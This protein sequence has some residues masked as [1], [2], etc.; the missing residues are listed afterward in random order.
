MIAVLTLCVILIAYIARLGSARPPRDHLGDGLRG[1]G[2]FAAGASGLG[3]L[4][5]P[6]TST[7]AERVTELALVFLLFS[8][9]ARIDLG[10]LRRELGWPSRLLLIG[11]PLTMVFGLGA[12]VLLFPGMAVASAFLLSTMLCSTDAALGQRV[13]EDTAVPARVRQALDVESG[14]NDGLAVP[15]FLVAMDISM[16]DT[17]TRG[18][19]GGHQQRRNPDRLGPARGSRGWR[20]RW[21][22]VPPLRPTW[23]V[24]G[25]VATGVH[26]RRRPG[27]IRD[28]RRPGRQWLHRGVR[29][30][31]GIW[32]ASR[33][34]TGCASPTSPRRRGACW[35]QSPGWASVRW[36]SAPLGPR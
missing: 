10:S 33:A 21:P 14:L 24:A 32:C 1:L 30:R 20:S 13:V 25:S 23:L 36:R 12:G 16:A 19:G 3:L 29:G 15:F 35:P 6:L 2:G 27:G 31:L 7:V 22:R 4:D 26:L 18:S 17:D 5:V 11:L 28:R 8:D 34:S 9:S